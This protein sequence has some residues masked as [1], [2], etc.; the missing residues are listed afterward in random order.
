M[1]T[2]VVTVRRFATARTRVPAIVAAE[3]VT[4]PGAG[5]D[6]NAMFRAKPVTSVKDVRKLAPTLLSVSN[7]LR[8]SNSALNK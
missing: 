2:G 6:V 8:Y 1:V 3:F 7:E 4:A 5:A